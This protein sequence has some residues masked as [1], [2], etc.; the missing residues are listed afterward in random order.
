MTLP[1]DTQTTYDTIGNRE[2]LTNDIWM[3]SPTKT[4]FMSSIS[5]T[6]ASNTLHEW[7]TDELAPAVDTNAVLEGDD[8]VTD[9]VDPT[10]R[11]NNQTQIQDKVP[12][13]TGTQQNMDPA[14][15]GNEL[16]YQ[17]MKRAKELKT[18]VEKS[19]L[20]NKAKVVGNNTTPRVMAGIESWIAT[21]TSL[22]ATG[23][24]PT[25]DGTDTRGPGTPRAFTED[26]L[27]DVLGQCYDEGGEPDLILVGS[28]NKQALS[29]FTGNSTRNVDSRDK[30]LITAI[31]IYQ[32]DWGDL[33]V[34]T[35]RFQVQASALVLE[36]DKWAY[37]TLRDFQTDDLAK[38]GD[39]ERRQLLVE[40]T[41]EAR[42]Q[43]ASAIVAD[44]TTA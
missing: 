28:F 16:D 22:G 17:L 33:Q 40:G 38:T 19:L 13:V 43:K 18:D 2:D 29:A 27:K 1:A 10:V 34:M 6:N 36:R 30:T 3:I 8:A 44:L 31:D 20:A 24:A 42:N 14:G 4:P 35:D 25:G 41:L 26:L 9:A 23:T 21:N 5:K 7:Q 39:S 12:R 15:R 37:S 11:L 32:S